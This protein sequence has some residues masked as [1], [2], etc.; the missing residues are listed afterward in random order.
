MLGMTLI[1]LYATFQVRLIEITPAFAAQQLMNTIHDGVLVLDQDGIV[2]LVNPAACAVLGRSATSL[3]HQPPPA[4]MANALFGWNEVPHFPSSNDTR[5]DC[6]YIRGDGNEVC[7][8]VSIAIMCEGTASPVAAVITLHDVTASRAAQDE[9]RRLAYYDPLTGLANRLL[10]R[11]RA[12]QAFA[13]AQRDKTL[14]ALLFL[15]LDR[16]KT[17][18]DSVG[19]PA[20]DMLL[21]EIA[22]RLLAGVRATDI[23]SRQGGDE[24]LI[25]LTGLHHAEEVTHIAQKILRIVSVPF[26]VGR[27]LISP[28]F[29]IG[30]GLYPT[31]ADNFSALLGCADTALYH[32]KASGRN[33]YR[34]FT[35]EMDLSNL[36][37]LEL[38][39]H[40][41]H[42]IEQKQLYLHYQP[43]VDLYTGQ[44]CGAEALLR[45]NHPELGEVSPARFIPVAE[46]CGLIIPIGAWVI[47][48]V[49][50]QLRTWRI[51]GVPD[52]R[53]AVN[54]STV[55]FRRDDIALVVQ[56]A[57][58]FNGVEACMLEMEITESVLLHETPDVERNLRALK[59]LGVRLAIDDFGVGYSSF[60][61][62]KKFQVDK[63]K[64]DRSF[65][66]DIPDDTEDAAI[67]RA[68][69][70][71]GHSLNL[72]IVAE[73]VETHAQAD[74][75]RA[76]KC[77]VA[78]GFLFGR[79][80]HPER[81]SELLRNE[82]AFSHAIPVSGKDCLATTDSLVSVP[83]VHLS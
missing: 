8:N 19:H 10:F 16:F 77:Q 46:D 57:L 33:T 18:N 38:E 5:K 45:W 78:Q 26:Q 35:E 15:D 48:E 63:L 50:R 61:Y 39:G 4:D 79:P 42:A 75:L 59:Q 11:D 64:I 55:Q 34:F 14:V 12:E 47:N 31:N 29:S 30:I 70:Q 62:L 7:L 27:C 32:A 65:I 9:I 60:A 51:E 28:S 1:D 40:L 73:G 44:V 82:N 13:R 69:V 76:Y 52:I 81:I 41:R 6:V 80:V 54:L 37:R 43:Q 83:E 66:Q 72:T 24:F 74:L 53:I 71:L 49:C 67:V 3:L 21:C 25:V 68:I 23:V 17:I 36:E 56:N 2:R 20:A 22:S 58:Q